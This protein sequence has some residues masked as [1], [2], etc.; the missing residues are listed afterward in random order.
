LHPRVSIQVRSKMGPIRS[1]QVQLL[2]G[3]SLIHSRLVAGKERNQ[4]E[5]MTNFDKKL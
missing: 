1:S 2:G 4:R 3:L 5:L